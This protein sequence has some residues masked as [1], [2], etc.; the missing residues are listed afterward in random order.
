MEL[1]NIVYLLGAL[2]ASGV[3]VMWWGATAKVYARL[4]VTERRRMTL[5]DRLDAAEIPLSAKEFLLTGLGAGLGLGLVSVLVLGPTLLAGVLVLVGPL[6][7]YQYWL[8]R[9]EKFRADYVA[10]LDES[11]E[12]LLR[13]YSANPNLPEALR[14]SVGYMRPP[15]QAD[16]LEVVGGLGVQERLSDVLYRV[17]ERRKNQYF[18][19]LAE[20]LAS[21]EQQGGKLRDVLEGLRQLMRGIMRIQHEVRARQ[22]QPQLEGMI[23][24]VAPFVFLIL[25][26]LVLPEYENGY[27]RTLEGQGVLALAVL[28]TG[29]SYYLSQRIAK[30]GMDIEGGLQRS[31]A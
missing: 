8:G 17:A 1:Q 4:R 14:E 27:Y 19:M 31:A 29:L 22:T 15:V 18:D 16:F 24:A 6:A 28:F 30:A 13:S 9:M 21:R 5:Q 20:A 12:T 11:V 3:A 10:A 26:K 25:M 7:Y 23:V 2:A